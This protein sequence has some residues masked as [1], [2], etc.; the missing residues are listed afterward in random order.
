M[1]K[2]FAFKEFFMSLLDWKLLYFMNCKFYAVLQTV[3]RK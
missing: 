1:T 3:K 2:E